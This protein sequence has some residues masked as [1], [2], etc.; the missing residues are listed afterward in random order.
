MG[1]R[2]PHL[3]AVEHVVV[4]LE[5]GPGGDVG[6]VRAGPGL[7][8]ALAPQLLDGH[9]RRQEAPLLLL[10][11]ERDQG[12]S[13]QLL[14]EVVDP[15]GCIGAGVLLV[16][17]HL[18]EQGEAPAAVLLRPADAGP[19]GRGEVPVPGDPLVV[20]LVLASGTALAPQSGEV[21][22][23]VVLQPRPDLGAERLVLAAVGE[24]H[25]GRVTYQALVWF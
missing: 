23:E 17:D 24:I 22:G 13:E 19:A 8:V 18:L 25:A 4:T 5:P 15:G 21:A 1:E 16:E 3:L 12:R 2:G 20:R 6:Q 7:G 14:T 10:I 11:A 9:D